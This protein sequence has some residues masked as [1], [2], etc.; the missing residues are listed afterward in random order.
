VHIGLSLMCPATTARGVA[1]RVEQAPSV[2]V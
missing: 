1:G 2:K